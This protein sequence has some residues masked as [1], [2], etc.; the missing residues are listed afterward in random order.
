M[1]GVIKSDWKKTGEMSPAEK[2]VEEEAK[3]RVEE[4]HNE[5][6]Q[7]FKKAAE[8]RPLKPSTPRYEESE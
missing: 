8:V 6:V 5:Q 7:D 3:R 2:A 4:V 1:K